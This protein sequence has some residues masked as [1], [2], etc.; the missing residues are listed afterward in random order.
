MI[1]NYTLDE[2]AEKYGLSGQDRIRLA[3]MAYLR[4]QLGEL[5]SIVFSE[6]KGS[7]RDLRN[8]LREATV[9]VLNEIMDGLKAS[10]NIKLKA[11]LKEKFP[12]PNEG[13]PA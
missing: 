7:E 5:N 4:E 13:L 10:C 1:D 9:D 3:K 8:M 6:E 11:A 12:N 2:L